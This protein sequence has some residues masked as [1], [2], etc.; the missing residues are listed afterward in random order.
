MTQFECHWCGNLVDKENAVI[1]QRRN[2]FGNWLGDD[3]YHPECYP[4]YQQA[5]ATQDKEDESFYKCL[6]RMM[7]AS[8]IAVGIIMVLSI[9]FGMGIIRLG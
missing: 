3:Y 7:I 1:K 6:T 2:G 5:Q 9:L 4:K 8:L